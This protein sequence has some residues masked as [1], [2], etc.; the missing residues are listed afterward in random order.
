M[1]TSS[2]ALFALIAAGFQSFAADT[3]SPAHIA[4]RHFM[5]GA[6]CGNYLEVPPRQSWAVRHTTNDLSHMRAEGFDHVRIP[7]GWHHYIG[8]APEFRLSDEIFGK[9]DLLVTNAL[10]LGLNVLVNTHHF[11][12]FT[13]EPEQNTDKFVAISTS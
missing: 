5:R 4:M 7:V 12:A 3:N 13:S 6:N 2:L 1:R 8:P 11:D 9:V 10:A